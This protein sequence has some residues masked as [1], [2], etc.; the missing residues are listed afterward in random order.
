LST[1]P[2]NPDPYIE[3]LRQ[4]LRE[5]GWVDRQ[6][7]AIEY[8]YAPGNPDRLPELAADRV[9]LEVELI[10]AAGT[11]PATAAREAS[12]TI[13]IVIATAGDPVGEGLA[14]S[15]ARPGG[16][17][18]GV[19]AMSPD[20]HAKRVELLR[21]VFPAAIRLVALKNP[22]IGPDATY[23]GNLRGVEA[24]AQRYGFRLQWAEVR[25]PDEGELEGAFTALMGDPPDALLIVSDPVT[26]NLR[27][28]IAGLALRHR[29]PT[30]GDSRDSATAGM[31]IGYG[32]SFDDQ[33]RRSA[34]YVDE[35]L[36]GAKPADLPIE[37]PTRFD[38]VIN[39]K[40][41]Q[42]LGMTIPQSILQRATE[43]IQ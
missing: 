13:P 19:S 41:A 24:G 33:F 38:F 5:L 21:E 34:A 31:L 29:L 37:Q 18:T 6:N 27:R 9:R 32:P 16:N 43:I 15:L 28:S 17:V 26:L 3:T 10:H 40:T 11:G 1:N 12:A 35:I 22:T 2:S 30:I 8:R 4:A 20:L 23:H 42:A 7:L 39:L 25:G 14:A 36:R